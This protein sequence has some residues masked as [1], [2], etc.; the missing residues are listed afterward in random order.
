MSCFGRSKSFQTA[1]QGEAQGLKKLLALRVAYGMWVGK[2]GAK[3][4]HSK[5]DDALS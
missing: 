2:A 3:T 4:T 1:S 5:P